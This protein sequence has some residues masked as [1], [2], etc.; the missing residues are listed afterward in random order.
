MAQCWNWIST[1]KVASP[2]GFYY[3]EVGE[4]FRQSVEAL[5]AASPVNVQDD[6][7]KSRWGGLPISRGKQLSATVSPSLV[8][9]NFKVNIKL[10]AENPKTPLTGDVAFFLHDSF[11]NPIKYKKAVNSEASITVTAY[12]AFTLGAHT[13]DGTNLE[14]DLNR[15]KG[16]PEGFYW[17]ETR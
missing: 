8:P 3:K 16:Y 6:L 11:S 12:E 5:Y 15:Q 7:Q 9:G 4:R 13:A 14:L 17:K 2:A 1:S 10:R